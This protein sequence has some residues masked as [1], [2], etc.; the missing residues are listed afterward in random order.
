METTDLSTRAA[1]A[2]GPYAGV[3]PWARVSDTGE[4][5]IL[6]GQERFEPGWRDGGRW[7]DFGGGTEPDM[8]RDRIEAAAREAYEETMGMLGSRVEIE[9]ALR[10]AAQ[11]GR[12]QEARSPKGASVFLLEVPYDAALPRQ[13]ARVRAYALEAAAARDKTGTTGGHLCATPAKGYYEKRAVEW[14]PAPTLASMVDD[15]LPV[16]EMRARG[17]VPLCDRGLLRDDFARTVAQLFP[18]VGAASAAR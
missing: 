6:L 17:L 14:V 5:V 2:L 18:R 16:A 11:A 9:A 8:D 3:L 1:G 4:I 15:A 10:A 12:L 7:S 13:F